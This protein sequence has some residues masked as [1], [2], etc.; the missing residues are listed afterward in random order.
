[1]VD[2]E[3]LAADASRGKRRQILEQLASKSRML[4][5]GQPATVRPETIRY[6]LRFCRTGGFEPSR[7]SPAQP[8]EYAPSPPLQKPT[9][10]PNS[11][12][13]LH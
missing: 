13:G 11:R 1:M 5:S 4:Q 12:I 10:P 9:H 7:I 2:A 3:Y 8:K 6:W